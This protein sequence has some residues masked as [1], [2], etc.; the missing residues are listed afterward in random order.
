[1]FTSLPTKKDEAENKKNVSL[2]SNASLF[3]SL[4]YFLVLQGAPLKKKL[5]KQ[6]MALLAIAI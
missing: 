2:S 5:Y 4:Y 1:L 3:T 6:A